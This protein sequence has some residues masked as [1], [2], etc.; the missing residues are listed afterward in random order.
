MSGVIW[1]T[2]FWQTS[3][4]QISFWHQC[5]LANEDFDNKQKYFSNFGIFWMIKALSV[6]ETETACGLK[7]A[8]TNSRSYGAA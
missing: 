1:Q 2:S 8:A 7:I 3:F 6:Y 5:I 4:W